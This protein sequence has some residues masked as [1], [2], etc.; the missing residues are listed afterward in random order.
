MDDDC[1]ICYPL[2]CDCSDTQRPEAVP[3]EYRTPGCRCGAD[4][5]GRDCMCFEDR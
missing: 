3:D 2:G 5:D 1:P 4:L